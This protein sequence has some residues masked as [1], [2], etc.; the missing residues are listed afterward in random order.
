MGGIPPLLRY[1]LAGYMEYIE[2]QSQGIVEIS[3]TKG[4]DKPCILKLESSINFRQKIS[5][6]WGGN[7]SS[8]IPNPTSEIL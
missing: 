7:T 1:N 3:K 8:I 2:T 6:R 5:V 4:R